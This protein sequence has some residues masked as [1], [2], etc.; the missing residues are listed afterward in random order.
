MEEKDKAV[1]KPLPK[2]D[3]YEELNG[4]IVITLD[5]YVVA[6]FEKGK[7]IQD[8]IVIATDW[9]EAAG[10]KGNLDIRSIFSSDN[11]KSLAIGYS[12][13]DELKKGATS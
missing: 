11:V 10:F 2:F 8:Q 9:L 3:A 6:Y 7:G 4:R 1:D 13:E 5:D 12:N